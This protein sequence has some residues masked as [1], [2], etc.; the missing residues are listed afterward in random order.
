MLVPF[1][2][3][4]NEDPLTQKAEGLAAIVPAGGAPEQGVPALTLSVAEVE[5]ALPTEFDATTL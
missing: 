5:V 3:E 2:N 4:S 1:V